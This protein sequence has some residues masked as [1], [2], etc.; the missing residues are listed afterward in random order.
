MTDGNHNNKDRN[1]CESNIPQVNHHKTIPF[2]PLYRKTKSIS[3]IFFTNTTCY[4]FLPLLE[5]TMINSLRNK[6]N[7]YLTILLFFTIALLFQ[8]SSFAQKSEHQKLKQF[9]TKELSSF[10]QYRGYNKDIRISPINN[11]IEPT[12]RNTYF[13]VHCL[14]NRKKH[15]FFRILLI[16]NDTLINLTKLDD[17]ILNHK[18]NKAT[19]AIFNYHLK[20]Q[21]EK[22]QSLIHKLEEGTIK[23]KGIIERKYCPPRP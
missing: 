10:K 5:K 8:G 9:V 15:L 2:P 19:I 7:Y 20:H 6:K 14:K 4:F 3:I 1:T 11:N 16:D 13:K 18:K 22:I 23:R 17:K 12:E 21:N